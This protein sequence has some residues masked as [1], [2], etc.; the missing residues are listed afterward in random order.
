MAEE[1]DNYENESFFDDSGAEQDREDRERRRAAFMANLKKGGRGFLFIVVA[2]SAFGAYQFFISSDDEPQDENTA[3][4]VN[5]SGS[6]VVEENEV[7]DTSPIAQRQR[8]AREEQREEAQSQ[9]ETYIDD[10]VMQNEQK[11]QEA[12]SDESTDTVRDTG[13][14]AIETVGRQASRVSPVTP[15]SRTQRSREGSQREPKGWTLQDEIDEA[16]GYSEQVVAD[17]RRVAEAQSNHGAY[18]QYSSALRDDPSD[19]RSGSSGDDYGDEIPFV[20]GGYGESLAFD[21]NPSGESPRTFKIPP[22]TRLLAVTTVGHNSDT[23]GPI[24]FES[25]T[26]PLDGA[27]FLAEEAPVQGEAVVPRI[28][29][30]VYRGETYSVQALAVN[31]QTFQPGLASDVDNHYFSR[32]IPYLLGTFGGAYAETLQNNTT[33]TSPEG[34]TVNENRTIP[35]TDD[36]IAFTVGSG[37]GRMVPVLQ[38]Q[39][40][41]PVTITVD[42]GEQVGIWILGELE[43]RR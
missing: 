13:D 32:W 10:I 8:Q 38:Q 20:S 18:E 25:V 2:V 37:L 11:Q 26:P 7:P 17:L 27:V 24:A 30:M 1:T 23:G 34:S 41:R 9:G 12:A 31:A 35:D 42:S 39:I 6:A 29:R 4:V 33:T 22:D 28:T 43:V 19:S 40:D 3:S 21:Q 36:Q 5:R 15:P 14:L 16:K